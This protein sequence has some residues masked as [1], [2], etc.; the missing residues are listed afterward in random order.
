M[1]KPSSLKG[2]ILIHLRLE[3]V[4]LH[5]GVLEDEVRSWRESGSRYLAETT[6]RECRHLHDEKLIICDKVESNKKWK[7]NKDCTEN[8]SKGVSYKAIVKG[9]ERYIKEGESFEIPI[10]N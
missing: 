5:K 3:G 1:I 7:H 6:G 2:K 9:V 8:K 4:W 10:F